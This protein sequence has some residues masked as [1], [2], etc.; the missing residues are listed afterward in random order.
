MFREEDD[1]HILLNQGM[2]VHMTHYAF[3]IPG[4][5]RVLQY[6][7]QVLVPGTC[8]LLVAGVS[9]T[10]VH[11]SDI[12]TLEYA[13]QSTSTWGFRN[14]RSCQRRFY[15]ILLWAERKIRNLQHMLH[16]NRITNHKVLG[17][18]RLA[19]WLM[20]THTNVIMAWVLDIFIL[21]YSTCQSNQFLWSWYRYIAP[22]RSFIFVTAYFIFS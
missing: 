13:Y 8:N 16:A 12:F 15:E 22:Y 14:F 7:V 18:W 17:S 4:T 5:C 11:A 2:C 21:Y 9:G 20:T 10:F 1:R 3:M 6:T 19:G